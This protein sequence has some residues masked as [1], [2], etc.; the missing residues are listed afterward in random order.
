MIHGDYLHFL[1]ENAILELIFGDLSPSIT[2]IFIDLGQLS[3][4]LCVGFH[5]IWKVLEILEK[6]VVFS[7]KIYLMMFEPC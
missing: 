6:E 2:L 3:G 7:A 1:S 5:Q 4:V